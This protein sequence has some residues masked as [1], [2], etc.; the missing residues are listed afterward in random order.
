[1]SNELNEQNSIQELSPSPTPSPQGRGK[2]LIYCSLDIETTGFDPI[3]DEILEIGFVFFTLEKKGIKFGKE[4]SQ[5]FKPKQPVSQII[6][7]LTGIT[8]AELDKGEEI[9]KYLPEIQELVK[10]AVI[11][12]HNINFDIGFLKSLGVE[13]SGGQID[14]LDLAQFILPTHHSYN[15][16]N[17]MHYFGVP[18]TEAHRALAD[19]KAT[20]QVLGG[21]LNIYGNFETGLKKTIL[22][23]VKRTDFLWLDLLTNFICK[24]V[25]QT[26]LTKVKQLEVEA[27]KLDKNSFNNFPLGVDYLSK[28]SDGLKPL[29]NFGL[30]VVPGTQLAL[31]I[32]KQ[33][34]LELVM[35]ED[36][37]FNA[38]KFDSLK[39]KENLSA[40]EIKFI[41]KILVWENINWQSKNISDLN[42]SFFGGQFKTWISG[43]RAK[44]SLAK[45][46]LV[47][48]Y[49]SFLEFN[50]L[51]FYRNRKII[52]S[53]L[54]ELEQSISGLVGTKISW[55]K[56]GYE[57]KNYFNPETELGDSTKKDVVESGLSAL[58]LF[59]GL[60][61]ALLQTDPPGFMLVKLNDITEDKLFKIKSA[62]VSLSEKL[63]ELGNGLDS[64]FLKM[65]SKD[66]FN[67]FVP[68]DNTVKWIEFSPK[69]CA[70]LKSPIE[71]KNQA[72]EI[73]KD[74]TEI[75]ICDSI[76]SEKVWD[77]YKKRLGLNEHKYVPMKSQVVFKPDLFSFLKNQSGVQLQ[78]Q[79]TAL[80][81]QHILDILSPSV[82]PSA[83]IFGSSLEVKT[84][85]FHHLGNLK[86]FAFVHAQIGNSG[87]K[88]L[89][90]FSIHKTSLLLAS[91]RF[92]LKAIDSPNSASI[93]GN[94]EVKT[95]V[96]GHLPFEQFT[97]P[98]LDAVSKGFNN[99]FEEFSLP[100]ALM[101]LHRIISLFY[102]SKLK[103]VILYEAKLEKSYAKVFENYL[104]SVFIKN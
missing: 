102:T 7:G 22:S 34:G 5:L 40:D 91:D 77:L 85:Y 26:K 46:W 71:I 15:L 68:E 27:V 28:I 78:I 13:F 42:L 45:K 44:E 86:K 56:I 24:P 67:Y 69:S 76:P 6:L 39:Q 66:L 48:D 104:N 11:V 79:K 9:N 43:H 47:C 18:H 37:T 59:F 70:F 62:S 4:Y 87:N 38:E 49:G 94:L 74:F 14:T 57:L 72:Q 58:D 63:M 90:N 53:G 55:G 33:S 16:E 23:Y 19:A 41:L 80:T 81:E 61:G 3:K 100:R 30:L 75:A 35:S 65:L 50:K 25:K 51:G 98:Y 36:I 10:D 97:H 60:V 73:F 95:L 2:K 101:N 8:Q 31:S 84:F 17:L 29:K 103:K 83:V 99:P 96:L 12:G 52:F 93:I 54:A 82:L 21:L 32:S 92:I 64:V 20:L 89:R 88:I 1:M